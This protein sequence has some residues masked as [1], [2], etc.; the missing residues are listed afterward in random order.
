M[1]AGIHFGPYEILGPLGKGGMG[2]VHRAYDRRLE[3]AVAIKIVTAATDDDLRARFVREAQAVA[4]VEHPHVCRIYD[5]GRDHDVDYLVMEY[6]DGETLASRLARGPLPVG[7]AIAIAGQVAEALA[8]TH[9]HGLVHR[10]LKPGH[11]M[12]TGAGAKVLDFGLSGPASVET[13]TIRGTLQYL[14]PEQIDGQPATPQSD[15]FALGA[16]LDEML[17]PLPKAAGH[18]APLARI[19]STCLAKDPADRWPSA[20]ALAEALRALPQRS[21]RR[22]SKAPWVRR[23]SA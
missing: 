20:R 21:G 18:S 5:L 10:D 16:I 7:D 23:Q 13:A 4:K 8:H 14:S 17:A 22:P 1:N 12:L 6:L 2:E 15:L 3:R 11:V 19:V 9:D